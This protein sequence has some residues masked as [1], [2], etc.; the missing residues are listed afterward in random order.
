MSKYRKAVVAVAGAVVAIAAIYGV[1]L[2]EE[3]QNGI[4]TFDLLATAAGVWGFAN[5]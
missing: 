5:D 2:S 4:V 3:T 1:D